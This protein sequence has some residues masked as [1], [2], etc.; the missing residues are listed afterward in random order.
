M[1]KKLYEMYYDY[2]ESIK[3]IKSHRILAINRAEDEK[4]I[5]VSLD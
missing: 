1:S 5:S 3:Y 2:N 4:V